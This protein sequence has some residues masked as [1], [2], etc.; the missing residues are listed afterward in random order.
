MFGQHSHKIQ[1]YFLNVRRD[2]QWEKCLE[3]RMQPYSHV[4][5]LLLLESWRQGLATRWDP[6]GPLDQSDLYLINLTWT[7]VIWWATSLD[8]QAISPQFSSFLTKPNPLFLPQVFVEF[9][10]WS[11]HGLG[12]N[13]VWALASCVNLGTWLL[14]AISNIRITGC[15]NSDS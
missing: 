8:S 4:C 12:S 7:L 3:P 2:P 5:S 13:T 1:F 10:L 6:E 14:C 9:L 15:Q 11:R